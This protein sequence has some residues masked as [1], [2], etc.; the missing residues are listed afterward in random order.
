MRIILEVFVSPVWR[1]M[2]NLWIKVV[3]SLFSYLWTEYNLDFGLIMMVRTRI[4]FRC[5]KI[6]FL[7]SVDS[8]D[9]ILNLRRGL[10]FGYKTVMNWWPVWSINHK[11]TMINASA[12][13]SALPI[14]TRNDIQ[15]EHPDYTIVNWTVGLVT[16]AIIL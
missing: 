14:F 10:L 8:C 2:Y 1:Q 13:M 7:I 15:V 4:L 3:L 11:V 9:Q 6:F 5:P 16:L 12:L